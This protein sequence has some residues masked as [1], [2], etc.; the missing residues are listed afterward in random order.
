M[1][2]GKEKRRLVFNYTIKE[3]DLPGTTREKDPGADIIPTLTPE[4]HV[5]RI[6]SAACG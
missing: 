1:K 2:M 5:T 6:T 4:A 3:R